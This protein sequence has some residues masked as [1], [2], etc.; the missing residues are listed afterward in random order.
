MNASKAQKKNLL[1]PHYVLQLA[2]FLFGY[3]A[4]RFY[5]RV[6]IVGKT[7]LKWLAIF[8]TPVYF[9]IVSN[10]VKYFWSWNGGPADS[11]LPFFFGWLPLPFFRPIDGNILEWLLC[12]LVGI[13]WALVGS[14]MLNIVVERSVECERIE[15]KWRRA[16][17]HVG[18]VTSTNLIPDEDVKE[19]PPVV[20]V[21]PKAFIVQSKGITPEKIQDVRVELSAAMGLFIGDVGFLK[22]PDGST[23]SDL[24]ELTYSW[25]DLPSMVPLRNVPVAESGRVVFGLGMDGYR[26]VSLE[27]MVHL[28]VSGETG[29][30]KSVFLRSLVT[31]L[32]VTNRDAV[33]VGIDFKGGAEF[34]FFEGLG[35]FVCVDEY[36]GATNALRS[37][38]DEYKRRVALVRASECDSVYQ[39]SESI[40]SIIIIID[41]AAEFW[42]SDKGVSRVVLQDAFGYVDKLARLG[43]FAGIHLV[44]CTQRASADVI[45]PQIRSMLTTR[46]VFKV[47]QKE[48]SIMM[49]GSA[50]AIKLRKIAGRFYLRAPDG[51][52]KELQASYVSKSEA[53]DILSRQSAPASSELVDM[54]RKN[55]WK[56]RLAA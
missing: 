27:D 9:W 6:K 52:L 11:V 4:M 36:D 53:K 44:V 34:S 56:M 46:V 41:E 15:T 1:L 22:K 10:V 12:I 55:V 26:S 42:Q 50:V 5:D 29:S 32:M 19:F 30:G 51:N 54:L 13:L 7:L 43:R 24:L 25:N 48:D 18:L 40:A 14:V 17:L 16:C 38:Y 28:G 47:S 21:T 35:N 39:L 2:R 8:Y 23:Y 49:L 37:V 3:Q 33:I 20:T 31:Q 45:P